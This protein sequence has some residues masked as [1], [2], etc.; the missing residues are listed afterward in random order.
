MVRTGNALEEFTFVVGDDSCAIALRNEVHR[1][2]VSV[3]IPC[4]GSWPYLLAGKAH[5]RGGGGNF[6]IVSAREH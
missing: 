2:V 5:R 6:W 3:S 4:I 1:F